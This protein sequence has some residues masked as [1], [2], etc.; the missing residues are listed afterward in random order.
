[1]DK[2]L[3]VIYNSNPQNKPD[4]PTASG[5]AFYTKKDWEALCEAV[6]NYLYWTAD[7]WLSHY[8]VS[9][10]PDVAII[11]TLEK[12]ILNKYLGTSFY[13]PDLTVDDDPV[14]PEMDAYA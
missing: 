8:Q 10:L 4:L 2:H 6:H 14:Y 9:E 7:E 13:V 3:L 11:Q 5:W 12:T 1:M